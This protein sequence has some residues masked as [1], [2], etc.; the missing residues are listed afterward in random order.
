LNYQRNKMCLSVR[1]SIQNQTSKILVCVV[2][3]I[4]NI[5]NIDK[6]DKLKKIVKISDLIKL[7]S[8]SNSKLLNIKINEIY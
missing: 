3:F 4:W 7:K 6:T 2:I 5:N 8:K 1:V